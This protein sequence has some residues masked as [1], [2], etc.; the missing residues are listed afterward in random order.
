MSYRVKC[1]GAPQ[2]RIQEYWCEDCQWRGESLEPAPAREH[3]ACGECGAPAGKVVGAP[4]PM[5]V[6]GTAERGKSDEK[7]PMALDTEALADGMTM[8]EWKKRR[9]KQHDE[10]RRA[11]IRKMVG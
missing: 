2:W 11:K 3:I 8:T 9:R 6:W 5:T 7:P 10:R 4:K 1:T